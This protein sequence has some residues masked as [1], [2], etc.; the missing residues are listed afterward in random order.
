MNQ[1]KFYLRVPGTCNIVVVNTINGI[2]IYCKCSYINVTVFYIKLYHNSGMSYSLNPPFLFPPTEGS[3][4]TNT[5]TA[6]GKY[7]GKGC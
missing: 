6:D 5:R 4:N 1:F 7:Y 2:I 3:G